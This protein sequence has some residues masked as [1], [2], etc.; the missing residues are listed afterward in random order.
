MCATEFKTP[1]D[2]LRYWAKTSSDNTYLTQPIGAETFTYTW[3]QALDEVSRVAAYLSKYP[4]GSH[5]AIVSLNC[6]HWILADLAIQMAGHVS[7]PIY[8]TASVDTMRKILKHS[9]AKAVFIGKMFEPNEGLKSVTTAIGDAE[10]DLMAIYQSYPGMFDWQTL[11]NE[12]KPINVA[13]T[14]Q[15]DDLMSII[16]TSGT[17]G[18][19]KGVMV[20]YRAVQASMSLVK[21]IIVIKP[22]DRFVSYLPLAHV[23]ERMAVEFGALFNGAHVSFIRSLETFSED[24]K[25]AAPTIFF[26]VPR[27]WTKIKSAIES[28]LGGPKVLGTLLRLPL[29]GGLL[30]KALVKKLGFQHVRYA[31][32]AAA[33]VNKDVL[34]WFDQLGVKLNEAYGMSETCGLSHMTKQSDTKTGSV[35]RVIDGC[36]CQISASG[37]VLLRNPAMMTGYYKQ[38][39]LTAEVIDSAGWLHTGDQGRIDESG[40]LYITGRVKDIFKTAKGK[41]IAPSPIEQKFQSA[42]GLEHMIVMGDG[43]TQ[44]FLVITTFETRFDDDISALVALCE[45]HLAE[46]NQ[47]LEVQERISHVFITEDLWGIENGMLTPTLK[48]KRPQIEQQYQGKAKELM[49][50]HSSQVI[51][52]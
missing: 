16:Y 30:K 24:V 28:K 8:P 32:C 5:I 18:D 25:T 7:I 42:L 20:P 12:N 9:E 45:E 48:M 17:T 49:S 36:E 43:F 34:E 10:I 19:P 27:I 4:P 39:E 13:A 11:V 37:E 51:V 21:S 35:G 3:S 2:R 44:P 40:F 29:L 14:H 50:K 15:P 52:L 31:L 33:A 46:I 41:Y 1:I 26:G 47:S 22:Q 38:P 6:A 23:A